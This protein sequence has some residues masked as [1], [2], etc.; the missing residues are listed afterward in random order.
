MPRRHRTSQVIISNASRLRTA[1]ST[2][3][4]S[5]PSVRE[6]SMAPALSSACSTAVSTAAF[7]SSISTGYVTRCTY[8]L[9]C[10]ESCVHTRRLAV[11]R[12]TSLWTVS[13]RHIISRCQQ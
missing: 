8:A 7:L 6:S 2:S 9:R 11:E 5:S 10:T 13:R 12:L 4:M 1:P 3:F